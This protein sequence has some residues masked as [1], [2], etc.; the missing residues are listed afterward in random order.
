M[1]TQV[2][3][4]IHNCM[5]MG[6]TV[7]IIH[8]YTEYMGMLYPEFVYLQGKLTNLYDKHV[9]ELNKQTARMTGQSQ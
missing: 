4:A 7:K 6:E 2:T 8:S 3:D 5:V 1:F 9:E